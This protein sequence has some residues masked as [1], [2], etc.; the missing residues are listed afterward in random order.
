MSSNP[1][2]PNPSPQAL[3]KV[4]LDDEKLGVIETLTVVA[5]TTV[6]NPEETLVMI[7]NSLESVLEFAFE[8]ARPSLTIDD[9]ILVHPTEF[10]AIALRPEI[11]DP[12]GYK[13]IMNGRPR[14]IKASALK[15]LGMKQA[16]WDRTTAW[17]IRR[18]ARITRSHVAEH[19]E[20]MGSVTPE[21]FDQALREA[22]D[23]L[24]QQPKWGDGEVYLYTEACEQ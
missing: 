22:F 17:A 11:A 16:N 18:Q 21:T 3:P 1:M 12:D 15:S 14:S 8:R 20:A 7:L 10:G 5:G 19:L 24:L 23:G 13:N 9:M 6:E 2:K 4:Q